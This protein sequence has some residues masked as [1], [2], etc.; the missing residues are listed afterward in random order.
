MTSDELRLY[1]D[2][3]HWRHKYTSNY[4]KRIGSGSVKSASEVFKE[5]RKHI[6]F[7]TIIDIG[8]GIGEWNDG[9]PNYFGVDYN[10]P[11]KSLMIDTKNYIDIDLE[12]DDAVR[13]KILWATGKEK[14][15][16]CLC[17]EVAEH[18]SEERSDI[19]IEMLCN[20]SDKVLFGAAI[21]NQG[22]TGH[23]NEQWQT[24]WAEKFASNKFY[25]YKTD[26]RKAFFNNENVEMW[27]KNNMILF[28]KKK[29][30]IDYQLN[31]VHPEM[32][33]SCIQ[34]YKNQ[35]KQVV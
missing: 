16:L 24:Y 12:K 29:F 22:G 8:C 31:F 7:K 21:P 26:I 4:Y 1:V 11:R 6:R 20:L 18:I 25:P 30:K 3:W 33:T 15:D 32:F 35:L 2:T 23:I 27:Y 14:F 28:T 17:L 9:N 13:N 5:L 10:I 19:L 34:H